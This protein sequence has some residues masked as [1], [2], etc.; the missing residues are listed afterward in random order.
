M[1]PECQAGWPCVSQ[2]HSRQNAAVCVEREKL[3]SD[4]RWKTGFMVEV[5]GNCEG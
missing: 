5:P 2:E 1:F 4:R 3:F